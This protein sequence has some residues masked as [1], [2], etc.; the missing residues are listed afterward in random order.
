MAEN[1]IIRLRIPPAIKAQLEKEAKLKHTTVSSL[2]REYIDEGMRVDGYKSDI[3]MITE[4]TKDSLKTVLMPQ[5]ER[6]VKILIKIGKISAA[7]YFL[8]LAYIMR[9]LRPDEITTYIEV[10]QASSK[11]GIEYINQKDANVET[12]LKNHKDLANKAL[13]MTNS[14]FSA[15]FY[16]D[17]NND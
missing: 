5:V 4:I 11:L 3:D 10:A 14:G 1:S 17:S 9:N 12:Y 16:E 7:G 6:L 8:L 2:V 15:N 13:R